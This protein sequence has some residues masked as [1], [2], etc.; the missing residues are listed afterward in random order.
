MATSNKSSVSSAKS[1]KTSASA[2]SVARARAKAEAAKVRASY[3]SQEAKLKLEKAARE[4]ERITKDAQNQL[5]VTRIDTELEVLTLHREADAAMVEAQVWE[6]AAEMHDVMENIKSESEEIRLRRTSDYVES[7]IQFQNQS[8]SPILLVPPVEPSVNAGSRDSFKTSRPTVHITGSQPINNKPKTGKGNETQLPA[9]NLPQSTRLESKFKAEGENPFMNVPQYHTPQGMPPAGTSVFPDPFA[10]YLAR[11]DLVTSGL[12]QFDDRPENFRAWQSS[13]TNAV[14]EVNLTATQELDLMTKWLGKESSEQVRRI[15]SVHVNNPNRALDKAWERLRD[16][17]AAPEIIEQSLFQRLDSFP[18]I[19]AKDHTKLRELGDLLMEIRGAKEEGYLMGL[20]YLD[21]SRG[22]GPIVEKLPYGLQEKWVSSGSWYKEDN[23]GRFPPFDYFC[24][25]VCYEA[26]KRNDP[27]FIHQSSNATPAK[28]EKFTVRNFSNKP[29]TVHKTDVSTTNNDPNKNCPLHLKPHP[30]KRCRTFRNKSLGDRKAFLKEKGI[31][32]KCCSSTTHLA[33]D[34]KF[35]VKC[36]ECDSTNHDAAMHPG[37]SPQ[38]VMASPPPQDNG[39]E[40]EDNV[41]DITTSCTEVCGLGQWGRSCSKICLTK[42]YPKGFKNKAIKAY[43]ILDD[44]SNRSLA[45]PE[46]FELF[47]VE[48]TPFSYHL[49][50][51]SG[52]IETY[53]KKAEGFQIE[54]LDGNVLISLPSLLECPEIPNNRA[55]IPTPS[56]VLHQPHLHHIARHIPELDPEAEILLLLGRDVLRAHKVRQQINGPHDAPFAQRLDLGWVV[57]GEVCLGNVHKP[58][59]NS[60]KTHV[61]DSGRHSIFQPCTSFMHVKETPPSFNRPGKSPE[62]LLGRTVFSQNEHDNKPAPSIEDILFLKIMDTSVYRDDANNWVAPL[63]FKEPR[64]RLPNNRGLAVKR[65]AS[66]QR[67]F[68]RKPEMQDQYVS[69]MEKIFTNG[70]EEVAPPLDQDEEC[71]YLPSF[72]VYHPQK[73]NQIRVVF[74]SSAQYS[75]VSLNDTL[76]TGPDLNNSLLGVLLRFRKERVAILADI[77]QMFHCF[78]V[79]ENHRNFLRFLWHQDNDLSKPVIEYQMKVHV[80]GNAPSPAVAIYG[81][82]RAIEEG[83]QKHGA[84]TVKFVKRHFYVDDGLISLPSEIEAIDLLQRTQPS[85][86][87]W[88]P[89]LAQICVKLSG[90][91]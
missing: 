18:K 31:C 76:L 7:Q 66:L 50:T 19:S 41:T 91:D 68:K 5:E 27:S 89:P 77:Q 24:D 13:F 11:R 55:E 36:F 30:L 64:Q 62:R 69:F 43:V 90:S 86:A 25:F 42:I 12:Y 39:G 17:Y 35:F 71:W 14:A 47:G 78:L 22:I 83:A 53:G 46:F 16:C 10:Q 58:T 26:K 32:F 84:D 82:R 28:P 81:L 54:S 23:H 44:Q 48:S 38:S 74:D 87:E 37:P 4:A 75:G 40:R 79:Q 56:A 34:C 1:S 70:H 45:R 8:P 33:K 15:R 85:L 73:P 57:I 51:C 29:I 88:K 21:T 52:I 60:Y 59:V 80:F 67:N 65:F 63:P 3:A 49:R 2:A 61:L 6:D 20:S 72:G 9:P